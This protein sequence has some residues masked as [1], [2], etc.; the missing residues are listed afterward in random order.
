MGPLETHHELR[1]ALTLCSPTLTGFPQPV[2]LHFSSSKQTFSPLTSLTHRPLTAS[3]PVPPAAEKQGNISEPTSHALKELSEVSTKQA[4]FMWFF[5]KPLGKTSIGNVFQHLSL[6]QDSKRA[7]Q[8]HL[9][10]VCKT[11][12]LV[13]CSST[14][15]NLTEYITSISSH[16]GKGKTPPHLP[17]YFN[18]VTT[19]TK[20]HLGIVG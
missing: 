13:V 7:K 2:R 17:Q 10:L 18:I 4:D 11:R 16:L 9:F 3:L 14:P 5:F 6:Q 20:W 1:L 12:E 15:C 8:N 19:A